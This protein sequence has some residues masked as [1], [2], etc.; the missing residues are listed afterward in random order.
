MPSTSKA[1]SKRTALMIACN[2][3]GNL[4][5][6]TLTHTMEMPPTTGLT[7][8]PIAAFSNSYARLPEQFFARLAPT[9]VA[10]PHLI[11]FNDALASELGI[12]TQGVGPE[13]LA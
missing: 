12:D 1:A 11:K 7:A 2:Q 10:K 13:E 3:R 8:G 9:P 6:M 5:R 4:R